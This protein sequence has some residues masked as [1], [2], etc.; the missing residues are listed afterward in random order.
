MNRYFVIKN[1]TIINIVVWDGISEWAPPADTTIELAVDGI[2]TGWRRI[3]GIWTEPEPPAPTQEDLA[4]VSARAKLAA[5]GLTEEE[6]EA[7]VR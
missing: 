6:I 4:K 3:D 1:E 2:G 7:L 5:L